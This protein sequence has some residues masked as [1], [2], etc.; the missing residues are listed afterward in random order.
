MSNLI[1]SYGSLILPENLEKFDSKIISSVFVRGFKL[2]VVKSPITKTNYHYILCYKTFDAND[3]IPGF[4]IET[5][6]I[7]E[8]DKWE[9]D[10]YAR[11]KIK[12]FDRRINEIECF[13]YLKN[14]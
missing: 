12:C 4:L 11:T 5:D 7:E 2:N 14:N 6:N 8:I 1:F 9:G 10:S 13:I 3:V